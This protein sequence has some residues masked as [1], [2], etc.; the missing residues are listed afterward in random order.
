[1]EAIWKMVPL[2][3]TAANYD[4]DRFYKMEDR[5]KQMAEVQRTLKARDPDEYDNY[6]EKYPEKIAAVKAYNK[7][8][9]GSLKDLRK[10][11]NELQ[12]N[13]DKLPPQELKNRKKENRTEQNAEMRAILE[14]I[15]AELNP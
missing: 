9:N 11:Y 8:I 5:I 12:A 15:E 7:A 10:E 1:M 6:E 13:V 14:E 3:G 2:R 4:L